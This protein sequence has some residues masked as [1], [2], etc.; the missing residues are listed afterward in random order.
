MHYFVGMRRTRSRLNIVREKKIR[1]ETIASRKPRRI[2]VTK[3]HFFWLLGLL[4]AKKRRRVDWKEFGRMIGVTSHSVAHYVSRGRI[5]GP[6]MANRLMRLREHG[7]MIHLEDFYLPDEPP[8]SPE[9]LQ[10]SQP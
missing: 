8:S 10:T 5:G 6:I 7:I 9:S 3:E 4:I 2:A 1:R